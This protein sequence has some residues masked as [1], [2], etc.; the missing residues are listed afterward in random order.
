VSRGTDLPSR[1]DD[2]GICP[3]YEFIGIPYDGWGC[4]SPFV[5]DVLD[6]GPVWFSFFLRSFSENLA[7]GRIWMWR[8]SEYRGE[9][10]RRKI[11]ESIRFRM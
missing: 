1:D 4:E 5:A 8:E 6:I 11:K 2:G 7:V 10:V 3:G 9:Y